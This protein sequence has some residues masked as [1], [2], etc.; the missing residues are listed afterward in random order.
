MLDVHPPHHAANTWRDF[1]IHIATIVVG[2]LIAVG[3]EQVVEAIH[4]RT[5]R[6]ELIREMRE[7]ADANIK[8]L[9]FDMQTAS[10][11]K[12]W[13]AAAIMALQQAPIVSGSVKVTL[14]V[15]VS[16]IEGHQPS[17]AVWDIAKANGKAGLV[18]DNLAEI[19]DRQ[20]FEANSLETVVK[21]VM[22]NKSTLEALEARLHGRIE[23]GAS[24]KLSPS[25]RDEIVLA[26]SRNVAAASSC[27]YAAIGWQAAAQAVAHNVQSRAEIDAETDRLR[28]SAPR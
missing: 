19:Y 12:R 25:Q 20:T 8:V 24:L 28:A 9:A 3:L 22:S 14:P 10:D 7:E 5:E 4:H 27:I 16:A 21:N 6:R 13:T 23:G 11:A 17:R 2:L 1:F 18:P 26:L 15:G